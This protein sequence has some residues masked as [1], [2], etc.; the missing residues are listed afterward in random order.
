MQRLSSLRQSIILFLSISLIVGGLL[1]DMQALETLYLFTRKYE[2]WELDDII[3]S[4][5]ASFI[6]FSFALSWVVFRQNQVLKKQAHREAMLREQL[7]Q[8]ERLRAMGTLLGGI[9]HTL[10]NLLMP[11]QG[12]TELTRDELPPES[13]HAI[14]L[15]HVLEA[16]H[17]ARLL[18]NDLL[19]FSRDRPVSMTKLDATP[20]FEHLIFLLQ[21][22]IPEE[23]TLSTEINLHG[24]IDVDEHALRMIM[25]NL[26]KNAADAV[27]NQPN[28]RIHITASRTTVTHHVCENQ[29][30]HLPNGHYVRVRIQDTGTGIT[31]EAASRL[32]E[33]FF[34]TKA[35]GKGSGLGLF[36]SMA[37]AVQMGGR[38]LVTS[39]PEGGAIFDVLIAQGL[40]AHHDVKE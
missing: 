17:D 29:P 23:M 9:G 40:A 10:N 5:L 12:L 36:S 22:M 27:H 26:V 25:M 11:I 13:E 33:P 1:I 3:L 34:T 35:I 6:G 32:F 8:N 14:N 15:T 37:M 30:C 38:I 24:A 16:V 7:Q 18:L 39:P 19:M 20:L 2:Q 28:Q 21:A 4:V 31:E